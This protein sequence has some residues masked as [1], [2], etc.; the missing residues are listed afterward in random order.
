MDKSELEALLARIDIWLLIFGAIVV[1]GVAGESYFGVRHWW[2][3][4]KLQ[5]LQNAEN[6]VQ[7][8]E[9]ERLRSESASIRSDT[10]KAIERAA[11][12]EQQAA[13]SNKIAEQERLARVKIEE[14]LAPRRIG[15]KE[16][17]ALVSALKPYRGAVVEVT[18]LGDLEAGQFADDIVSVLTEAG[19]NVQSNFV[20]VYSPPR[21]GLLCA[22]N[23]ITPAGK[24][25]VAALNSLPTSAVEAGHNLPINA[26]I[27]VGLRPPP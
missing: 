18:K 15:P 23:D 21:Y 12:A 14:R 27:F 11:H 17:A 4:R 13:E 8:G 20:G 1:V 10:A 2:N 22:I 26:H 7:Q 24:A 19:W 5:A 25:L 9:I 3:S 16:H 6:L